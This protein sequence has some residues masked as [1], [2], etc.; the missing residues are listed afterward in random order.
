M[1]RLGLFIMSAALLLSSCS[2]D[3][4]FTDDDF[5]NKGQNGSDGGNGSTTYSSS[6]SDLIGFD[7]ALDRTALDEEETVPTDETADD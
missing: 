2:T 7:I 6:I 4:G 3:M 5:D 1:K